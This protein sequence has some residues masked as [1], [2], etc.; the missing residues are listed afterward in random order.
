LFIGEDHVFYSRDTLIGLTG[1]RALHPDNNEP[2]F[3]ADVYPEERGKRDVWIVEIT[4]KYFLLYIIRIKISTKMITN[5]W[6][7]SSELRKGIS[8]MCLKNQVS[9]AEKWKFT[10]IKLVAA[11]QPGFTYKGVDIKAL[12]GHAVWGKYGFLMYKPGA[13]ERFQNFMSE[14]G[15]PSIK[16][17]CN[18]YRLNDSHALNAKKV[19]FLLGFPWKGIFH[20]LG[21]DDRSRK[22]LFEK[23]HDLI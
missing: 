13:Q 10:K 18:I 22:I 17:V 8:E 19:W 16:A 7:V 3:K 1:I 21:E 20:V 23:K 4:S 14:R 6:I 5:Q 11:K 9:W 15:F 2:G 12:Y